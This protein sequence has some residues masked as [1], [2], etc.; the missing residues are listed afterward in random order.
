MQRNPDRKRYN[1][2]EFI[3]F[4]EPFK[5]SINEIAHLTGIKYSTLRLIKSG[6]QKDTPEIRSQIIEKLQPHYKDIISA[7]FPS[8]LFIKK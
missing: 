2:D 3:K 6:Y 1:S 7:H 8:L 5:L 4:I